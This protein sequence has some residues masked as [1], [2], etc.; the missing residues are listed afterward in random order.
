MPKIYQQIYPTS[1]STDF[2]LF[3]KEIK[4]FDTL[5]NQKPKPINPLAYELSYFDPNTVDQSTLESFGLNAGFIK[6]MLNY[7]S[8]GGRFYKVED[9]KKIYGLKDSDYERLKDYIQ[10]KSTTKETPGSYKKAQETEAP[11]AMTF[12]KFD[13]NLVSKDDL[14]QLGFPERAANNLLKFRS[15]GGK[16]RDRMDLAKI[17][18]IGEA[19]FE[20][21]LPYI[22]IEESVEP[23]KTKAKTPQKIKAKVQHFTL[24]ANTATREEWQK[25]YGVGPYYAD[26]IIAYRTS[27]G[28]FYDINQ[29][30]EV[31]LP[32]STLQKILPHLKIDTPITKIPINKITLKELKKHPYLNAKQAKIIINYRTQHGPFK[33]IEAFHKIVILKPNVIEKIRPYLDLTSE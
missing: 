26:K 13:P 2:S 10:I 31:Y 5:S 30:Q 27:L 9:F 21:I 28:G 17:Y 11:P 3:K 29:L 19:Y 8:K 12:F 24:D 23:Q 32:D 20:K 6:T 1:S 25:I 4:T 22:V 16:I 18:G 7:R 14:R 15:K 33:E